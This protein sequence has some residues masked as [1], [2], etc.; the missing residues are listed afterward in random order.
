M[1]YAAGGELFD[2]ISGAGRFSEAEVFSEKKS[3]QQKFTLYILVKN[4]SI[5]FIT[6]FV[7]VG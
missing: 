4:G 7:L 2:R 1:E 5:I 6:I 3:C